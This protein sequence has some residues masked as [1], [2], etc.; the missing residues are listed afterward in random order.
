MTYA[1]KVD[2]GH[3]AIVKALRAAGC[4]V[5]DTSRVGDGF[6]DLVVYKVGHP[7][8]LLEVKEQGG[9]IT[10]AQEA[11]MAEGWPVTIVRSIDEALVA[12]GVRV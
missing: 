9:V 8:R 7:I 10:Q 3:G 2:R 5:H 11:F 12:V 4:R 6:P 1:R